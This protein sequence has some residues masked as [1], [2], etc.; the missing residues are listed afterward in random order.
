MR[1][2][3]V[4]NCVLTGFL[5]FLFS[6]L[7]ATV[8]LIL[9]NLQTAVALEVYHMRDPDFSEVS[10]GVPVSE[11]LVA[12][13]IGTISISAMMVLWEIRRQSHLQIIRICGS[14]LQPQ[15]LLHKAM[16]YHLF[17]CCYWNEVHILSVVH[18]QRTVES[19]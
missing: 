1:D 2:Q 12:C 5:I 9:F 17:V 4:V 13:I 19:R 14:G 18:N 15:L 10:H 16:R 11:V 7:F 6:I 8:L 3:Y